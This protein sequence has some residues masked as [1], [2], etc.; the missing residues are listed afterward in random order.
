MMTT[1]SL[2]RKPQAFMGAGPHQLISC[3]LFRG[4]L[5][6]AALLGS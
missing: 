3:G 4:S 5:L 6:S 2:Q 1:P